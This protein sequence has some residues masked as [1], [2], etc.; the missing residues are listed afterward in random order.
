MAQ[1]FLAVDWEQ[2]LL[3]PPSLTDW[4][5]S[6]HFV[7]FVLEAVEEMDLALFYAV[8]R[9]D[10]HGRAAHDPKMMV[11][12]LLYAYARGE[13]SSR[14]IERACVEDVAYRVIAANRKPDHATIARFRRRHEVALAGLF[15]DVLRLCAQAGLGRGGVS[16]R[17]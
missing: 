14:R 12:L 8:Y 3:L 16:G 6:D 13:R 2:V 9:A 4:L 15:V 7:W 17:R 10:G 11:A 5:P 1:N